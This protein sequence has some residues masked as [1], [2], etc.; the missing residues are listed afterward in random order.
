M[1]G[2]VAVRVALW[3]RM[4]LAAAV[5]RLQSRGSHAV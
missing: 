5:P 2:M 3:E 1:C 4:G